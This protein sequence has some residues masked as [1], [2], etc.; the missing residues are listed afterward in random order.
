METLS[1]AAWLAGYDARRRWI[2]YPAT[3][4][5]A[6]LTGA[7]AASLFDGIFSMEGF[8]PEGETFE[9][10][11]N[12]SIL[13]FFI[14][15]VAPALMINQIF[16]PDLAPQL[17]RDDNFTRQLTFLR[18]LPIPVGAIVAGRMLSMLLALAVSAPTFFAVFYLLAGG[19]GALGGWEFVWFACIWVGYALAYGGGLV[20]LWIALSKQAE[21]TA[22]SALP[23]VL[24]LVAATTNLLTG[25]GLVGR[26]V[27]LA[28]ES[29]AA[30]GPAV[31]L[32]GLAAFALW[33]WATIK[34]LERRD[35]G[36]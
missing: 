6:A 36:A 23:L 1:R 18:S 20:Y 9:V 21:L 16:N 10:L 15:A 13:D 27:E 5:L 25:A 29:G 33:G 8:G 12:S 4:L 22:A 11:F 30:T 14:L 35:L 32:A 7:L 19:A 3:A 26:A 34:R 24:L 28:R 17:R 31:L 2:S